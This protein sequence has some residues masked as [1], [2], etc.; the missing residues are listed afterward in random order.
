MS[1]ADRKLAEAVKKR[2][3]AELPADLKVEF[4]DGKSGRLVVSAKDEKEDVEF[5]AAELM[6][7]FLVKLK[8]GGNEQ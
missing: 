4:A 6:R 8:N 2:M 5:N 1:K 3:E 7:A